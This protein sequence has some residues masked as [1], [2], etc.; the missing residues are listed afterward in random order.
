METAGSL[1]GGGWYIVVCSGKVACF[2]AVEIQLLHSYEVRTH[3]IH[4]RPE[5]RGRIIHSQA[6]AQVTLLYKEQPMQAAAHLAA[7]GAPQGKGEGLIK[8]K[9]KNSQSKQAHPLSWGPAIQRAVG[10]TGWAGLQ[11]QLFLAGLV[12]K[13]CGGPLSFPALQ[14]GVVQGTRLPVMCDDA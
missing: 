5:G 9:K 8:K 7:D 2:P 14:R 6:T 13:K 12:G 1:L 10:G 11:K 4:S 3:T